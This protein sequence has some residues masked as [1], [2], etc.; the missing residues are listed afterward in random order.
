MI[1]FSESSSWK[2]ASFLIKQQGV[3][4]EK[5]IQKKNADQYPV[6]IGFLWSDSWRSQTTPD[7]F[8]TDFLLRMD[9]L[10]AELASA[11]STA[12]KKLEVRFF[13]MNI[14][15]LVFS[16]CTETDVVDFCR[17]YE[18]N[19]HIRFARFASQNPIGKYVFDLMHRLTSG[20]SDPGNSHSISVGLSFQQNYL[21]EVVSRDRQE[22]SE[23]L[24]VEAVDQALLT[25]HV[26]LEGQ[27]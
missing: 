26:L 25:H 6:F 20:Q 13:D 2:E 22:S 27:T 19:Y 14:L 18:M 7:S 3:Y 24:M 15:S 23:D 16:N 5:S 10:R 1:P 21:V 8:R 4:L 17:N 9:Q 11:F 12:G